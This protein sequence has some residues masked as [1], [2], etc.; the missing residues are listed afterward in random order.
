MHKALPAVKGEPAGLCE[1]A[2]GAAAIAVDHST[3][4]SVVAEYCCSYE[5][6]ADTGV[7]RCSRCKDEHYCS[8]VC[9]RLDWPSHKKLCRPAEVAPA[10]LKKGG[11]S[12][13]HSTGAGARSPRARSENLNPDKL[14]TW[15]V[16][17]QG[18]RGRGNLVEAM[19]NMFS[20]QDKF[21]SHL[22][23]LSSD[24]RI[25]RPSNPCLPWQ[26][27]SKSSIAS[28]KCVRPLHN[29]QPLCWRSEASMCC[30]EGNFR[31]R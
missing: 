9:L 26:R 5:P 19:E 20:L 4:D 16:D 8:K 14:S 31:S 30:L 21:F 3:E 2:G 29:S 6:Y 1:G 12:K 15:V 27:I 13:Q 28:S 22:G 17:K 10:P 23:S 18:D 7:M 24:D 11:P 25:P